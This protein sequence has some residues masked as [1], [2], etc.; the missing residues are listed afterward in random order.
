MMVW[1]WLVV[2]AAITANV[3]F[4]A[5]RGWWFVV[6]F[7]VLVTGLRHVSVLLDLQDTRRKI[8]AINWT[9]LQRTDADDR[10]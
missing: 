9:P 7:A 6:G 2:F 10:S 8:E 1:W 3:V 4:H 5:G